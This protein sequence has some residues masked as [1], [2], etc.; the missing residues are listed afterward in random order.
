MCSA[1]RKTSLVSTTCLLLHSRSQF[2]IAFNSAMRLFAK[3]GIANHSHN[4]TDPRPTVM[5]AISSVQPTTSKRP[6]TPVKDDGVGVGGEVTLPFP[7]PPTDPPVPV[8]EVPVAVPF[9][10]PAHTS[11]NCVLPNGAHWVLKVASS[12][13]RAANVSFQ[14]NCKRNMRKRHTS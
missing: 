4:S 9:G 6:A 2:L 14:A 1:L 8:G 7:P 12:T 3:V 11:L 13:N 10:C 5:I